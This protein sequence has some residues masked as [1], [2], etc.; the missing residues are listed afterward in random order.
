[1]RELVVSLSLESS[2][3]SRNMRTINNQI[4]EI[5]SEFRA[6]S[7]GTS[8]FQTSID[9]ISAQLDMES[10]KLTEQ[11]RAVTQYGRALDAARQKLE[12]D[13]M[14]LAQYSQ[15]HTQLEAQMKTEIQTWG[16]V[17]ACVDKHREAYEALRAE[18]GE[19]DPATQQA[20]ADL[21]YYEQFNEALK[22]TEGQVESLKKELQN[23]EDAVSRFSTGLNDAKGQVR[24]TEKRIEDLNEELR[25]EE[26]ALREASS[27]WTAFKSSMETASAKLKTVSDAAMTAGRTLRNYVTAP[28]MG[29]G[30]AAVKASI[31]F[32]SSFANVRKTVDATEER[33]G[34]LI[35]SSKKMS[36]ELATG[37]SEIN[38]VMATAGQLGVP[39]DDIEG[40]TEIMI[41]LGVACEDIDADTAATTVAK[42]MNVMGTSYDDVDKLGATIVHLGNNFATTEGPIMEMAQRMA[43]AGKIVGLTEA[44]VLG[45]AT[46]LS[47]VGIEAQMGGSAFS[48]A[49]VKM[50]VAAVSGGEELEQ[51]AAISGMT[52]K[53]FQ[54]LWQSDP[55]AAFQAF[56]IGLAQLD[57]EGISAISVLNDIGISEIRLRDTLLRTVNASELMTRAQVTANEA[58]E[59]GTALNVEFDKRMQTTDA[60]LT[61]LKN[62][63]VLLSQQIGDDLNPII[64]SFIE[65]ASG[66]IESLMSMDEAERKNVETIAALVASIGPALLVFG[67]ASKATSSLFS[68]VAANPYVALVTAVMAAAVAIGVYAH[69]TTDAYKAQKKLN[70]AAKEWAN[71]D[72][73]TFYHSEEGLPFF[74]L[75]DSAFKGAINTAE[76]YAAKIAEIW[77]DGK[78]ESKQLVDELVKEW[79]DGSDQLRAA[80]NLTEEEIKQLDDADSRIKE[81]LT[82]RRNGYLTEKELA[83]LEELEKWRAGLGA[84]NGEK[85]YEE[86]QRKVQYEINRARAL[87]Q[88]DASVKVY[89]NAILAATQGY[90]D[91]KKSIDD[92]FDAGEISQTEYVERRR[93]AA[94]E[95]AEA[96]KPWFDKKLDTDDMKDAAETYE[97]LYQAM[98]RSAET[99]DNTY[100]ADFIDGLNDVDKDN[101]A[102]YLD[103]LA[104][105]EALLADGAT[106]ED[107]KA[108]FG[109][110]FDADDVISKLE[111][112]K[113]YS[114]DN[115]DLTGLDSILSTLGE[116]TQEILISLNFDTAAEEWKAWAEGDHDAIT[117]TLDVDEDSVP[118]PNL[119]AWIDEY[120][121]NFGVEPPDTTVLAWIEHYYE[122]QGVTY[123]T[124]YVDAKIR[125]YKE[126]YGVNPPAPMVVGW[127]Q[128]YLET[129]NLKGRPYK[130][131]V[132][133]LVSGYDAIAMARF[134]M[135]HKDDT[136]PMRVELTSV[137]AAGLDPNTETWV[138]NAETG[139]YEAAASLKAAL[140]DTDGNVGKILGFTD[141]GGNVIEVYI[142]PK[143]GSPEDID[144]WENEIQTDEYNTPLGKAVIGHDLD[145]L[146]KIES[147]LKY[148]DKMQNGSL[149]TRFVEGF[150]KD[151]YKTAVK[152]DFSDEDAS[153]IASFITAVYTALQSGEEVD[154]ETMEKFDKA[155]TF[156]GHLLKLGAGGNIT[157][158]LENT[159]PEGI[160]ISDIIDFNDELD[161]DWDIRT[162]TK[163]D[164]MLQRAIDAAQE[165]VEETNPL[166]VEPDD[167]IDVDGVKGAFKPVGVNSM[168]G[169]IDGVNSRSGALALALI[170]A[171]RQAKD[172]VEKD[173][174]IA[175]PSKVWRDEIGANLAKGIGE[176]V[177]QEAPAQGKIIA[178]AARYL[179]DSAAG[180]MSGG[181]SSIAGG[182]V[183]TNNDVNTNITVNVSGSW[184][185]RS[186]NDIRK[187][188]QQIARLTA[189]V[190]GGYGMM[191][192]L[193][194]A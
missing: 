79:T 169:I 187:L 50:E 135:A 108:I 31:D 155:V 190:N 37:T 55:A 68:L 44:Q 76:G 101:M 116:E 4:K 125:E 83:E 113:Q 157:G 130:K 88:D 95:Y 152:N 14:Y 115:P 89:E 156:I 60:Q 180:A 106:S 117:T 147:K 67:K 186:D 149:W 61:N 65:R 194:K 175:S 84:G 138:W 94:I 19:D 82:Q 104:Q 139:Q 141:E 38:D 46:A 128:E 17:T 63:A 177:M 73:D 75:D 81:L 151:N 39:T 136:M 7:A 99:G 97:G 158:A 170:A 134:R 30:T 72:F 121:T 142:Q 179:T 185:V 62:S 85:G 124:A 35:A 59:E 132:K 13:A 184:S 22:L 3:F 15:K 24:E 43:G 27:K 100:I 90:K 52:A 69:R 66:W 122:A 11:E 105:V 10:R 41:K 133:L 48:K 146:T 25:K 86:I 51:F 34:E 96:I 87:G 1:M 168:D 114:R 120:K 148:Y 54:E 112:I 167:L 53:E 123:P 192:Q 91:V 118:E 119:T 28:I 56:I 42:F 191:T 110:D 172:A 6:A 153:E 144:Q 32:E 163:T 5:E 174:E 126:Q 176:G 64:S 71:H 193:K 2:N 23:D 181:H 165:S 183:T 171:V 8:I 16:S 47:S 131:D 77:T 161:T 162:K 150:D 58:W 129:E 18:Y 98:A 21:E 160:K 92:M 33:F 109:E 26:D 159:L 102:E 107:L 45:F 143:I 78:S 12:Q 127:V 164:A 103:M 40:F 173:N 20:K 111:A 182:D 145:A 80:G 188:A 93:Q 49:L 137:D 140:T 154:N 70:D 57:D 74:G 9:R 36:T 189:R 29:L 166:E 178:N